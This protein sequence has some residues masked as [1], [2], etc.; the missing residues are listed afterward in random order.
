M[1][2]CMSLSP[3]IGSEIGTQGLEVAQTKMAELGLVSLQFPDQATL[4][5]MFPT[6]SSIFLKINI[7]LKVEINGHFRNYWKKNPSNYDG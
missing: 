7:V 1:K 4:F 6:P 3:S 5:L 2:K